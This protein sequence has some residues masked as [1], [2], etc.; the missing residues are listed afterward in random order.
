MLDNIKIIRQRDP[1][2]ALTIADLQYEQ[3]RFNPEVRE[4]EHDNRPIYNIVLA[5]MGG[6]ALAVQVAKIWLKSE[7]NLPFEIIKTYDLP[8]YVGKNTLVIA[9][10]YSGNTEETLSCLDQAI[11]RSAQIGIIS[12]GGE[13]ISRAISSK[14]AY[15]P[16]PI[17][18]PARMA[19]IYQLKALIALLVNFGITDSGKLSEISD[20]F[21][22]LHEESLKWGAEVPTSDNYAKKLAMHT[23]GKTAVFFCGTSSYPAAYKWK[24]CFNETAK[25]LAFLCEF[26]EFDHNEILGW[27]SHPIEKPFVVFDIVTDLEHPQIQKRFEISNRL[28]SGMRPKSTVINLAGDS[29][30]AQLLWSSVLADFVSIY[31]AI[32]NNVNPN[33]TALIEKLKLEL[34]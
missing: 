12:S 19:L 14:I 32:L 30:V 11:E 6:S 1:N 25:N 10:S 23:V 13:L 28:L 22:W 9:S 4:S 17:K 2:S 21:D 18:M 34:K 20:T 5:G 24:T 33:S 26:P 15:V 29:L 3:V 31:L 16:L 7:L 8:N 27:T